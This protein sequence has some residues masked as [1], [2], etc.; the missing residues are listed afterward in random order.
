MQGAGMAQ[1]MPAGPGMWSRSAGVMIGHGA[2]SLA[3]PFLM[4]GMGGVARLLSAIPLVGQAAAAAAQTSAGMVPQA[5]GY[6]RAVWQN[7]AFRGTPTPEMMSESRARDAARVAGA[8]QAL[9]HARQNREAVET[10][11][12][13]REFFAS[14][15]KEVERLQESARAAAPQEMSAKRRHLRT[16]RGKVEQYGH[17]IPTQADL[18]RSLLD[19]ERTARDEAIR[20]AEEKLERQR[21]QHENPDF[22]GPGL[23]FG[24]DFG[25]GPMQMQQAYGAFM[26]ARGGRWGQPGVRGEFRT[27][28]AAQTVHGITPEMAGGVARMGIPGGGG[29]GGRDMLARLLEAAEAN[30]LAGSQIQDYVKTLVDL[31]QAAEQRGIRLHETSYMRLAGALSLSGPAFAGV[32]GAR[33]AGDFTRAATETAGKMSSAGRYYLHR[34]FGYDPAKGTESWALAAEKML[35]GEGTAAAFGKFSK[36]MDIGPRSG[37]ATRRMVMLMNLEREGIRISP[38]Q[39]QEIISGG[40]TGAAPE[41]EGVGAARRLAERAKGVTPGILK[42]AAGIE[43]TQI[44]LGTQAAPWVMQF[45]RDGLKAAL[46][47][48]R[49]SS[50]L[51]SLA[52]VVGKSIDKFNTLLTLLGVGGTPPRPTR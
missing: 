31:G 30:K 46:T 35:R 1:Y 38:E 23:T 36:G 44:G 14:N 19:K 9:K 13:K 39:A 24:A 37:P 29:R 11:R 15:Q 28:L 45:E 5:V 4:P 34:A 48:Q 50:Q 27:A 16:M 10:W 41:L 8:E 52:N 20:T 32:Q 6:G 51:G 22:Y 12:F 17:Q 26:G 3:A 42:G 7:L 49:F 47:L 40:Y 25:I 18:R 33:V 2:Q 43:A 21:L